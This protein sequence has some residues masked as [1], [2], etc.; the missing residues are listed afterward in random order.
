MRIGCDIDGVLADFN[1]AFIDLIKRQTGIQFPRP[2]STYPDTWNYHRPLVAKFQE[3]ALWEHIKTTGFWG[4]LHALPGAVEALTMLDKVRRDHDI[5]FITSRPGNRAKWL[6]EQWLSWHGFFQATVLIADEKGPVAK[7]LMLDI[8]V[9]DKPENIVDV[10][11]A[12]K[13]TRCYLI[14]RPY[15]Q[16]LQSLNQQITRVDTLNQVIDLELNP[17]P[18]AKAA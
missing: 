13:K 7:G 16:M 14:N 5:Y 3:D 1:T 12:R 15:N 6:S 11:E 2:S 4:Q 9:D 17:I 8:F 18:L 10:A